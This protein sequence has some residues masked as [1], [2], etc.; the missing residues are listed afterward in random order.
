[1]RQTILDPQ[2]LRRPPHTDGPLVASAQVPVPDRYR[3]F[4]SALGVKAGLP[5][6]TQAFPASAS[7]PPTDEAASSSLLPAVSGLRDPPAVVVAELLSRA[8]QVST[9]SATNGPRGAAGSH[10]SGSGHS[11]GRRRP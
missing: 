9:R 11:R 3:G 10:S 4:D 6:S 7:I 2:R 8:S 1:M 5:R